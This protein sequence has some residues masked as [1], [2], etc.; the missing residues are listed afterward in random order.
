M[1]VVVCVATAILLL[2][3]VPIRKSVLIEGKFHHQVRYAT[4]CFYHYCRSCLE[5][6]RRTGVRPD[7]AGSY[8]KASVPWHATC[9]DSRLSLCL[10]QPLKIVVWKNIFG[11]IRCYRIELSDF[12]WVDPK[13]EEERLEALANGFDSVEEFQKERTEQW[14]EE[15]WQEAM[16]EHGLTF[17][18]AKVL[19]P[20]PM[21]MESLSLEAKRR[22]VAYQVV[23]DEMDAAI[24]RV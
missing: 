15:F 8:C 3:L 20:L 6:W 5:E 1:F 24:N 17:D 2:W 14:H 7:F 18:E 11:T 19:E 23:H 10:D 4:F 22:G 16:H 9:L 21:F 12:V 13:D